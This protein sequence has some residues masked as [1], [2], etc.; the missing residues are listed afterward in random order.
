M[1]EGPNGALPL[2]WLQQPLHDALQHQ[3]GH[4]LLVQAA[5]G[6]GA[7]QFMVALAQSWL[8]E[9]ADRTPACGRCDSCRLLQ[10]G[11]HPDFRGL[12]PEAQRAS[13]G[14]GHAQDDAPD[15]A[16]S[17]K[18]PSRQIRIDEVRAAI[19]WVAH[20]ASRGRAKVLLLHP[21]EAMNLQAAS[22]LLKTLEEPPGKA[23]L[24]LGTADA[25]LLL[26]TVRS[27]CQRV[28]LSPPPPEQA[29]SWLTQEGVRDAAVL[30]AAAAGAP[31]LARE[32]AAAGIDAA[33]WQGLP[34]A[35]SRGHAAALAGWPLPR[36]LDALQKLCH[37]AMVVAAG[38][39]PRYFAASALPPGASLQALSRWSRSLTRVAR[40]DEHPW[41]ES[42]LIDALV[43]EGRECWQDDTK[44]RVSNPRRGA[45]A[46]DTLDR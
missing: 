7:P 4:A 33:Q 24:L 27:R 34:R 26:P 35:V 40:H 10:S 12:L 23:R 32:L 25:A 1:V 14:G 37:D 19:D 31:L 5:N 17:R 39:S 44:Q 38:A 41:N 15:G 43:G 2:P 30:L 6:V 8:C 28:R 13:L 45:R 29:V 11:S 22:A 18:K 42:L 9:A 21:A 46:L 20:S 16:R 3:R 36:A